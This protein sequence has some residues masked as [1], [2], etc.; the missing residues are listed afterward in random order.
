MGR[1]SGRG[2]GTGTWGEGRGTWDVTGEMD[3]AWALG[4]TK[5]IRSAYAKTTAG[6]IPKTIRYCLR[7]ALAGGFIILY[8]L[9]T[10]YCFCSLFTIHSLAP[11]PHK[12]FH[13]TSRVRPG[14]DS[15]RTYPIRRTDFFP[16][17]LYRVRDAR[18]DD[19]L[20]PPALGHRM[21]GD[22]A[23]A[24]EQEHPL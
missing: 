1:G 21:D 4:A 19:G 24:R 2:R 14:W 17:Y 5:T 22:A 11:H 6:R 13:R 9:Y 15:A 16:G 20:L 12:P 7:F 3:A 8:L 18:P 23:F 10:V